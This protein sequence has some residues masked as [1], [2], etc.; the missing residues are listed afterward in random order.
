MVWF[1][2]NKEGKA[3]TGLVFVCKIYMEAE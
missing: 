1:F 3:Q 2:L